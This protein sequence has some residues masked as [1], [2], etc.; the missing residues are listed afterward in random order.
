MLGYTAPCSFY[1]IWHNINKGGTTMEFKD[2]LGALRR[3]RHISQGDLADAVEVSIDSLRRWEG[4]KQLPRLDEL[5][6]LATAL[7]LTVG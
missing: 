5:V 6:R 3:A 4:G 1:A 7:G 2:R